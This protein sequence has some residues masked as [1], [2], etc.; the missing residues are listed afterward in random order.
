M[1]ER[2]SWCSSSCGYNLTA[3]QNKICKVLRGLLLCFEA[4][5]SAGEVGSRAMLSGYFL[6][7]IYVRCRCLSPDA[8]GASNRGCAAWQSK[9]S[10]CLLSA[11]AACKQR[12]LP[13][14][15]AGQP[16]C[17]AVRQQS[18]FAGR[19]NNG[20][21]AYYCTM[22]VTSCG[23]KCLFCLICCDLGLVILQVRIVKVCVRCGERG[24]VD[25]ISQ[26]SL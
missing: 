23:A 24:A 4:H 15:R 26:A 10:A 8:T 6:P 5:G 25:V 21:V 18:W 12:E 7:S 2:A 11:T 22:K 17:L 1:S 3:S 9:N 16:D 13:A 20:M 14:S 19:G